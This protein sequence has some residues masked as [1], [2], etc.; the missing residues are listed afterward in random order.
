ME[1]ILFIIL[2]LAFAGNIFL[3][4]GQASADNWFLIFVAV[5]VD[6]F[7]FFSVIYAITDKMEASVKEKE[8]KEAEEIARK[9]KEEQT[10]KAKEQAR[11]QAEEQKRIQE[12]ISKIDDIK[13]SYT[14]KPLPFTVF[15]PIVQISCDNSYINTE[16]NRT[17]KEF[18]ES[19]SCLIS[20]CWKIDDEI[21]SILS[22]ESDPD[23]TLAYLTEKSDKLQKLKEQ[24]DFFRLQ[25]NQKRIVLLDKDK[26][27]LS[28][29]SNAFFRLK[30][31]KKCFNNGTTNVYIND[32]ICNDKPYELNMFIYEYPPLILSINDYYYCCFSNVIL[33]FSK[34]GV[35]LDALD[36]SILR[37]SVTRHIETV[38]KC[39]DYQN[40][41]NTE[42]DSYISNVGETTQ[43]WLHTRV[44]GLPDLR[45]SYNPRVSR[46]TDEVMY[47]KVSFYLSE[48]IS[49]TFS[50]YEAIL[51]LEDAA[52][53]YVKKYNNKRDTLPDFLALMQMVDSDSQAMKDISERYKAN[54]KNYFCQI[55]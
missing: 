17:V 45:Y 40:G 30:E 31:S 54:S 37:L 32:L 8:K 36:P 41:K 4:T 27:A 28:F 13:A 42:S 48:K 50:S 20:E 43:T 6:I 38:Y 33:E 47:G 25:I 18:K 51:A 55:T 53:K 11:R 9:K 46:R 15:N 29:L 2:F 7:L 1:I 23:S 16:I 3:F 12:V 10:R 21:N 14:L 26:N 24:S 22:Y 19:I 52:N 5:I 49:Y 44:N 39:N 35:Y 34:N